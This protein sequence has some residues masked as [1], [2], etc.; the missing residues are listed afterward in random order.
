MRKVGMGDQT[1]VKDDMRAFVDPFDHA[2]VKGAAYDLRVGRHVRILNSIDDGGIRDVVLEDAD[3]CDTF[4]I[5]PGHVALINT[6]E[7]VALPDDVLG[8][9]SLRTHWAIR[10]LSFHGGLVDPGYS[11]T[12]SLPIA[13]L[14]QRDRMLR[15]GEGVASLQLIKIGSHVDPRESR[16]GSELRSALAG[17]IS[18]SYIPVSDL[19][20]RVKELEEGQRKLEPL[21]KSTDFLLKAFLIATLV[22]VL[23]GVIIGAFS[24]PGNGSQSGLGASVLPWALGF[25]AFALVAITALYVVPVV[26]QAAAARVRRMKQAEHTRAR[27]HE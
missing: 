5:P 23:S 16:T 25:A 11:G 18:Q 8:R 19:S 22:G 14:G 21:L 13:N 4:A 2:Q 26:R 6:M 17:S 12:L 20:D 24:A 1:I 10:Q 7:E 3:N 15:L 27:N 9:L